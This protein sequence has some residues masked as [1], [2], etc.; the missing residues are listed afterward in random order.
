MEK[1]PSK[2]AKSLHLT[3]IR[4]TRKEL[5]LSKIFK[6]YVDFVSGKIGVKP[7]LQDAKNYKIPSKGKHE[8]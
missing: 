2:N 5:T 7:D 4:H 8:F 1:P 3:R 6:N